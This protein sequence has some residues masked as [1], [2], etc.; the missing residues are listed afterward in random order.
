MLN[1]RLVSKPRLVA[2]TLT[3]TTD[4]Y[5]IICCLSDVKTKYNNIKIV[6]SKPDQNSSKRLFDTKS[7]EFFKIPSLNINLILDLPLKLIKFK[8]KFIRK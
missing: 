7:I 5:F 8:Y 6:P 3:I 4:K 1:I 2:K